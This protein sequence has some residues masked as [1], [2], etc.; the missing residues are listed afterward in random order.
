[1]EAEIATAIGNKIKNI[2]TSNEL[3]AEEVASRAG[4]DLEYYKA[5]EDNREVPPL[6]SLV[7]IVRVLG[8][9]LGKLLDDRQETGPGNL[10]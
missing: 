9:R 10:Y 8:I 5:L 2:R 3:T 7:K 4:I 1:M 6:G